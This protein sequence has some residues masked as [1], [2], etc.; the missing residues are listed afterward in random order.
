MKT[1]FNIGNLVNPQKF[2]YEAV[3]IIRCK[4]VTTP[5]C[6]WLQQKFSN[7]KQL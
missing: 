2:N 7:L 4:Y 3:Q 1:I 5:R 6:S